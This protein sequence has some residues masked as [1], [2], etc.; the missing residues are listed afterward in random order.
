VAVIG[1]VFSS[2]YVGALDGGPVYA[3]LPADARVLTRESV[4]AAGAV[5][6]RLGPAGARYLAEVNDAFLSGLAVGCY[7]AAGVALA[8]AVFAGRYLPAR[9]R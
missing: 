7:V 8:G 2:V 4:G 1:S 9:A 3:Q 6:E 5:A